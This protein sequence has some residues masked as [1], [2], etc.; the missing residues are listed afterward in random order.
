MTQA[1]MFSPVT[2]APRPP[3]PTGPVVFGRVMSRLAQDSSTE[4]ARD[5]RGNFT[6]PVLADA[7]PI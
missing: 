6:C 4:P 7:L 2:P 3:A 1:V 5:S